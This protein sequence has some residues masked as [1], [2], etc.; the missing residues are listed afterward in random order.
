[1]IRPIDSCR[2]DGISQ[3]PKHLSE[4]P[5]SLQHLTLS[6]AIEYNQNQFYITNIFYNN[7]F[8]EKSKTK[9][10]IVNITLPVHSPL[11]LTFNVGSSHSPNWNRQPL[12]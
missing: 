2:E 11:C 9:T 8:N 10:N 3:R 4:M 1:M 12:K 7:N 5:L 6:F